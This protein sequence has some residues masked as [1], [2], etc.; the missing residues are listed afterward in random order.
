MFIVFLSNI[1]KAL[2]NLQQF[3]M[4]ALLLENPQQFNKHPVTVAVNT[5]TISLHSCLPAVTPGKRAIRASSQP[6]LSLWPSLQPHLYPTWRSVPENHIPPQLAFPSPS[7]H[8]ETQGTQRSGVGPLCALIWP[9]SAVRGHLLHC[10][11]WARPKKKDPPL[12]LLPLA[13]A[14]LDLLCLVPDVHKQRQ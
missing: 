4:L 3:S 10:Q 2:G 1:R 12:H 8:Q 7:R 13:H 5:Y 6:P 9:P 11:D 14:S